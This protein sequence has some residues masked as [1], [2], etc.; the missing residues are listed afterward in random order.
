[1]IYGGTAAGY[2]ILAVPTNAMIER[3]GVKKTL[4]VSSIIT[5]IG[6]WLRILIDSS[7]YYIIVGSFIASLG[8]ACSTHAPPKIA[9]KWF[10][11]KNRPMMS[12]ILLI[13]A[14]LGYVVGYG[15][16]IMYITTDKDTPY[17][18]T[19]DEMKKLILH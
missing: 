4:I 10:L 15:M 8:R 2:L 11:P 12:S 6:L 16:T 14:P 18:T 13:S 7:F 17:E 19:K 3:A 5:V 9:L 1:L